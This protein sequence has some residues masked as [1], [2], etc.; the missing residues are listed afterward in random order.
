MGRG[1]LF[2]STLGAGGRSVLASS[3]VLLQFAWSHIPNY[4]AVKVCVLVL[5]LEAHCIQGRLS[6]SDREDLLLE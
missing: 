1:C 2:L 3:G 5:L 4:D 6:W